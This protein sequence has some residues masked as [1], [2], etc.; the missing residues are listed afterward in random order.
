MSGRRGFTLVEVV[1]AGMLV[2]GVA[3]AVT[4]SLSQALKAKTNSSSRQ[5]AML[6][7]GSAAGLIARDVVN[8]VREGDLYLARVLI[9]NGESE[10]RARD[11]ILV[12]STLVELA[13]P[14]SDDAEGG[15]YEVQYRVTDERVEGGDGGEMEAVLWRRL[16]PIPDD[17]PDG[18]GVAFP[19][20]LGVESL[21]IEA[22]DGSVWL[23]EWDSDLDGY[24]YAVRI[25][26]VAA[27]EDGRRREAFRRVVAI[28]RVPRVY[29][30][31]RSAAEDEGE[32]GG[33]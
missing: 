3:S 19:V 24:P 8:V 2:A 33:R 9:E 5:S 6:R 32:G 10:G 27:S 12:F 25:E 20:V 11:E 1:V 4:I 30:V 14:T 23:S 31:D 15:E 22:F 16:D 21:S 26:V 29:S 7:A 13:R 17:V 18:G 28:D